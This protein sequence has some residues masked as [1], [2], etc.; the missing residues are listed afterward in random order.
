MG[1]CICFNPQQ[2]D[3]ELN[4]LRNENLSKNFF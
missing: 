2:K 4:N 3:L 1:V